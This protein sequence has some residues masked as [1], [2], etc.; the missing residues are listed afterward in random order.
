MDLSNWTKPLTPGE[1]TALADL[2]ARLKVQKLPPGFTGL[3]LLTE[4]SAVES[5]ADNDEVDATIVYPTGTYQ[6]TA[7]NR[8]TKTVRRFT[9]DKNAAIRADESQRLGQ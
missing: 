3:C 2:K 7:V 1:E 8:A 5:I 9:A 4:Y 6:Y